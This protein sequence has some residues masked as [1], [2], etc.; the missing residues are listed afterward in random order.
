M[1]GRRD[2]GLVYVL[3]VTIG[4]EKGDS[5]SGRVEGQHDIKRGISTISQP[6]IALY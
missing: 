1:A 3:G 5:H 2:W 6:L 4:P